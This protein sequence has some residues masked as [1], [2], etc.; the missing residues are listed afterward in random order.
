MNIIAPEI[1]IHMP[2][3]LKKKEE[4]ERE[5]KEKKYI[6]KYPPVI[7]KKKR[8]NISEHLLKKKIFEKTFS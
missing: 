7:E 8:S 1:K 4:K 2:V 5:L 6:K 3:A